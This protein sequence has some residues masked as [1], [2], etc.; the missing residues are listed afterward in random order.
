MA[1]A[2]AEVKL[3]RKRRDEAEAARTA[4]VS[5]ENEAKR[6]TG[7]AKMEAAAEKRDRVAAEQAAEEKEKKVRE[8]LEIERGRRSAAE[9]SAQQARSEVE[10]WRQK[11][12]AVEKEK[13]ANPPTPS[14][15]VA[16]E[17]RAGQAEQ[18]VVRL[19]AELENALR[20]NRELLFDANLCRK[21]L[22]FAL[23]DN[24]RLAAREA[25][26]EKEW[27]EL[28]SKNAAMM[29][30]QNPKQK[31]KYILHLK[32]EIN[33]LRTELKRKYSRIA[34]IEMQLE[35]ARM[36]G[37]LSDGGP[38]GRAWPFHGGTFAC[39]GG[40][41]T[42]RHSTPGPG[43]LHQQSFS[44]LSELGGSRSTTPGRT[45]E[46]TCATGGV[47]TA[48]QEEEGSEQQRGGSAW[49]HQLRGGGGGTLKTP[50]GTL[51][52]ATTTKTPRR[53]IP[54]S[55]S[56]S[57]SAQQQ[58]AT[59]RAQAMYA[60]RLKNDY[61]SLLGLV[62][63]VVLTGEEREKLKLP[64]GT[65]PVEGLSMQIGVDAHAVKEKLRAHIAEKQRT[66]EN[67]G[68][69]SGEETAPSGTA[70]TSELQEPESRP[71]GEKV[72]ESQAEELHSA[73][74][75]LGDSEGENLF[76]SAAKSDRD[77][78]ASAQAAKAAGT[79]RVA[80]QPNKEVPPLP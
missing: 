57:S 79:S 45:R 28:L 21:D 37:F 49:Q 78:S 54:S 72:S 16:A 65:D 15:A 36:A 18:E 44:D 13:A 68:S 76:S 40:N 71:H 30:H 48:V 14:W 42:S 64:G 56:S 7:K 38:E 63:Q 62:S 11:A 27:G 46:A 39:K 17:R 8:E 43:C 32:E 66:R 3:E 4:S 12:L 25:E 73:S 50:R 26:F 47:T 77:T 55:S 35:D 1:G 31:I 80:T 34:N 74:L 2:K 53:A 22:E 20:Q 60:E 23:G 51:P 61:Q 58:L 24:K 19:E 33:G 29:G 59:S 10:Y 67:L 6:A 9:G 69:G 70:G 41:N 75:S 52:G 5:E